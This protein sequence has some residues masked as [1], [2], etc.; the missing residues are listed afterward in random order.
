MPLIRRIPKR[1]FNNAAFRLI[2]APINVSS[3]EKFDAGTVVDLAVMISKG[4]AAGQ[5]DGIKILGNGELTKK[6]IV[7]AHKFSASAKE[8]IEKAGG[9]I[10]IISGREIKP[11]A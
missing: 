10:E 11:E 8:K 6:L 7:K 9:S 5:F 1:G 4:L 2:Y 3:L